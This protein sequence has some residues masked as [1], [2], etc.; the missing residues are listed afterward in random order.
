M[1]RQIRVRL[2]IDLYEKLAHLAI[3]KGTSVSNLICRGAELVLQ[4]SP[5]RSSGD[6]QTHKVCLDPYK[7]HGAA[8]QF[9]GTDEGSHYDRPR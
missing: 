1:E 9:P 2:P 7:M 4:R 3:D 8:D 6:G 5:R